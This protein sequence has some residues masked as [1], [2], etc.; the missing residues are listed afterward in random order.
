MDGPVGLRE[1]RVDES[2]HGGGSAR[3]ILGRFCARIA[4]RRIVVRLE[5]GLGSQALE[6]EALRRGELHDLRGSLGKDHRVSPT[7]E[8]PKRECRHEQHG[9]R[10]QRSA[11]RSPHPM[12]YVSVPTPSTQ[13]FTTSPALRNSLRARPT[14]AGVPV[15]TR[16]PGCRVRR[17]EM[18]AICSARLKIIFEVCESCLITSLTHS[19]SARFCGSGMSSAGTI[20]GPSG[21]AS[22]KFF[23][24]SQ[25]NLNG[26][27]S[28]TCARLVRSFAAV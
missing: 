15:R 22:S 28:G 18:C 2:I 3:P 5:F 6:H 16:S 19:L 11:H 12:V 25:S 1:H 10:Y 8:A 26:D 20:Q 21:Q 23:C 14:P 24:P 7:T 13:I 27:V 9:A 4:E 17:E